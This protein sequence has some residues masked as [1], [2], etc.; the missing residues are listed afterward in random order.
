MPIKTKGLWFNGR[1][2]YIDIGTFDPS[3]KDLTIMFWYYKDI[4]SWDH[5]QVVC[6]RDSWSATDMRW[7]LC[8]NALYNKIHFE[9]NGSGVSFNYNFELHKPVCMALVH[10]DGDTDTLYIDY[11]RYVESN[12][13]ISFGTDTASK[14]AIGCDA[15]ES[16]EYF[17]GSIW[18]VMIYNRALDSDEIKWNYHNPN[19][20]IK[21][22]LVLWYPLQDDRGTIIRDFSGNGING[23]AK[24]T[25]WISEW[26]RGVYFNGYSSEITVVNTESLNTDYNLTIAVWLKLE[27]PL[28]TQGTYAAPIYKYDTSAV[29]FKGY[30]LETRS[31]D[32]STVFAVRDQNGT[33]HAV[34]AP[35]E[36]NDSHWHLI[37]GTYDGNI[38]KLYIDTDEISSVSW[39]GQINNSSTDLKI[40]TGKFKGV[41][42]AVYIYNRA[43]TGDEVE[44][45]Y[46][47]PD[48]PSL[49]GLVLWLPLK[50]RYKSVATDYSGYGNHGK[51]INARWL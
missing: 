35:D 1:S 39:T 26:N 31:S 49:D 51:I 27:S 14:L 15:G 10:K 13:A 29:P 17:L 11:N 25:R 28:D 36:P 8:K 34:A 3:D 43:I 50:D 6:K 44:N 18:N 20:P 45:I 22:G 21:E 33:Y 42:G 5:E 48:K 7:Q 38:Q 41:I 46:N 23:V 30:Y 24:D 9:R 4:L 19:N 40:G 12:T 47:Y 16:R 37:I 2:S 32:N